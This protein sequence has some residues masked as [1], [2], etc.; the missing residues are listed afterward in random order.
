M[1]VNEVSAVL[2]VSYVTA[3]DLVKDFDRLELFQETT[4]NSRNRIYALKDYLDLFKL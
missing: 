4:K 2:E 1:N 3:N